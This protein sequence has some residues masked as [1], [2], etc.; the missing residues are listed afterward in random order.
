MLSQRAWCRGPRVLAI[1]LVLQL[2]KLRRDLYAAGMLDLLKA[3]ATDIGT[4]LGVDYS[5]KEPDQQESLDA[6]NNAA[7]LTINHFRGCGY[8]LTELYAAEP[9]D[10]KQHVSACPQCG[11]EMRWTPPL[12][13]EERQ[14][15]DGSPVSS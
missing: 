3:M 10:G 11:A 2:A 4:A 1:P 14:K 12:S 13:D 7:L 9:Y 8:E 6:W 15:Q 5:P